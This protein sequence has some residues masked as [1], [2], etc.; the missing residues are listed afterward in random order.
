M[1]RSSKGNLANT[2][3]YLLIQSLV[4]KFLSQNQLFDVN[5]ID[6]NLASQLTGFLLNSA[7]SSVNNSPFTSQQVSGHNSNNNSS[8]ESADDSIKKFKKTS[9]NVSIKLIEVYKFYNIKNGKYKCK[10][11]ENRVKI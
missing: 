8:D 10:F 11:C 6:N 7:N 2:N 5:S 4:T 9:G 3:S 1:K